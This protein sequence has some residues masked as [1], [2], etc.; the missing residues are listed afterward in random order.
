MG[1]GNLIRDPYAATRRLEST[2]HPPSRRA[3]PKGCAISCGHPRG[4]SALSPV[5]SPAAKLQERGAPARA[6]RPL[7]PPAAKL[8]ERGAPARGPIGSSRE[9]AITEV[10]RRR[11]RTRRRGTHGHETRHPPL[12]QLRCGRGD[13]G[14]GGLPPPVAARDHASLGRAEGTRDDTAQQ[15]S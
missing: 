8:Q 5:P 4:Q 1:A 2:W 7:P 6:V 3:S 15:A 11:W 13:G 14:E 9:H 10:P 12:L